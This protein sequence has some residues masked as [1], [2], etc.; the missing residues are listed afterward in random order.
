MQD[1]SIERHILK[2]NIKGCHYLNSIIEKVLP[3]IPTEYCSVHRENIKDV[4]VN[5][6]M[7]IF[8]YYCIKQVLAE[9]S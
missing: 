9:M 4:F 2:G 7:T 6:D 8:T 3:R 5:E 1:S